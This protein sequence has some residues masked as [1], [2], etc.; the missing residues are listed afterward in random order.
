MS[1][2]E[3][4]KHGMTSRVESE[5]PH[6]QR[7]RRLAVAGGMSVKAYRFPVRVHSGGLMHGVVDIASNAVLHT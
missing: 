6:P 1:Q 5:K 4:D 3:K 2:R 7:Q